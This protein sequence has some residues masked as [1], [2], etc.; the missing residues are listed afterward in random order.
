[1]LLLVGV[2]AGNVQERTGRMRFRS[3]LLIATGLR[4]TAVDAA[5]EGVTIVA[6]ASLF[7]VFTGVE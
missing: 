5:V 6:V 3:E 2:E 4:Q 7:R 1:V